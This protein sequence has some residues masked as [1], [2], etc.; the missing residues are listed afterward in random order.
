MSGGYFDYKNYALNEIAHQLEHLIKSNNV[1]DEYGYK[2]NY[3]D[4]TLKTFYSATLISKMLE[5]ML[6]E[7]DYLVCSDTSE[8][9]F[10]SALTNKIIKLL[11]S[12]QTNLIQLI[13][14]DNFKWFLTLFES[15][16]NNND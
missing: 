9:D 3:T 5:I 12:E 4:D 2:R 13:G 15:E 11:S 14:E 7:I 16:D 6:H 1:E 8:E 10:D